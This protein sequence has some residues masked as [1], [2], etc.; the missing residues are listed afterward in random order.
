METTPIIVADTEWAKSVPEWIYTEIQ[1]ER[2]INSMCEI[3]TRKKMRPEEIVGDAECCVWLMT[4]SNKVPLDG[5]GTA[6]Y[7]YIAAKVM[8]KTRRIKETKDLSDVLAEQYNKGLS[9]HQKQLLTE[10]KNKI[11]NSRGGKFKHPILDII[12]N[13]KSD[14]NGR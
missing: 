13:L 2:M 11:Y 7:L 8:L 5:D 9:E 4:A 1:A 12:I 14:K 3:I 6:I 10:L